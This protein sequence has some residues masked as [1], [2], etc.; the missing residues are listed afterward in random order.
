LALA[1]L[2]IAKLLLEEEL[3]VVCPLSIIPIKVVSLKTLLLD[4]IGIKVS[5]LLFLHI[6]HISMEALEEESVQE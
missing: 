6:S 3:G 2:T 4:K 1:S 5:H